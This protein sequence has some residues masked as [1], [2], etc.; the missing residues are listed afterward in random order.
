MIPKLSLSKRP[1]YEEKRTDMRKTGQDF[2]KAVESHK[3]ET[4]VL[5]TFGT[6]LSLSK[7]NKIRMA[8]YFE[9][10]E[11][12]KDRT[13]KDMEKVDSGKKRKKKSCRFSYLAMKKKN[14]LKWSVHILKVTR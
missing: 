6:E 5:R 13:F 9:T 12:C 8:E 14:A 4:A 2:K 10:P 11:Q 3:K 7:R 1:T